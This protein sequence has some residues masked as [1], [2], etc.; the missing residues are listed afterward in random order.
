MPEDRRHRRS[1][2]LA[3]RDYSW[4][5]TYF[6]TIC[7][8]D[9][10]L[11]LGRIEAGAMRENVL[12]RLER[13]QWL[14]IPHEFPNVELDAFVVMPNHI[15]GIIHLHRRV[16]ADEPQYKPAEFAKP[17]I[18]SIGWIV[19]AF[20]A[21]VTREAR[22]LLRRPT[23]K[24]WQKNYFERVVRDAKE[25]EDIYRHVCDNPK[26]WDQNEANLPA[27]APPPL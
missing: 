13:P 11:V 8:A 25:Y 15:H 5:G 20:K 23:F 19:R 2:R 21:R 12:G 18:R 16:I 17:Q 3:G 24:L 14:Q 27:N 1:I 7:A 9:R 6:I 26:N 4:P 22:Q 10:K